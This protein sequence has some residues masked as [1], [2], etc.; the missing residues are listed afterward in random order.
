MLNLRAIKFANI[1]KNKVLMNNN[2]FTVRVFSITLCM[3]HLIFISNRIVLNRFYDL[4]YSFCLFV[5]SWWEKWLKDFI[6]YFRK[7]AVDREKK[8][9]LQNP[10]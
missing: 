7:F 3:F 9:H 8:E 5:I 2:E 1:S 4:L 6:Q 10:V